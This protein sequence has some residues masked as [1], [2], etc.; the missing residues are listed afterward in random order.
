MVVG[1]RLGGE[2]VLEVLVGRERE[3]RIQTSG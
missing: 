1:R 3:M 2:I